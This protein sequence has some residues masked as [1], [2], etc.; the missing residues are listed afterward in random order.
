M[1]KKILLPTIVAVATLILLVFGATY[2]YFTMNSTNEFG[3]KELQATVE[4]MAGSVVLEQVESTLS[5]NVTR[6]M[7]S[8]DNTRTAYYASGSVTPANIA[9]IS[10]AGEG[11]YKCDYKITVTKTATSAANDLIETIKNEGNDDMQLLINNRTYF[12]D[13]SFPIT[14]TDTIYNITETNSKYITSNFE[15]WNIDYEQN[16]L[17]GKDVTLTYSISDFE[18]EL[19]E[20]TGGYTD[21]AFTYEYMDD[22]GYYE[23]YDYRD[24]LFLATSKNVVIPEI[25][26]GKD[27]VW[28]RVTSFESYYESD[29]RGIETFELPDSVISIGEYALDRLDVVTIKLPRNLVSVGTTVFGENGNLEN[30]YIP[31]SLQNIEVGFFNGLLE[32]LGS[33]NIYYEGTEAEWNAMFAKYVGDGK[34]YESIISFLFDIPQE[35]IDGEGFELPPIN[36]NVNY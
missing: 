17:K 19:S 14:I 36:Y 12:S 32:N 11:I 24:D 35:A 28:Y 21:L 23:V 2:A 10:V 20:S 33:L 15:I 34:E 8:E 16:Y 25:F 31:K 3:T 4:D 18:C 29:A 13:T 7:M 5:L 1:E 26:Q 22:L 30:I 6:E 9:K 27:G